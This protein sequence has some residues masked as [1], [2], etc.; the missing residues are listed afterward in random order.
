[1]QALTDAILPVFVLIGFGWIAAWR[2]LFGETA[3]DGCMKFAQSF[4]IP[5]LLFIQLSRL[6]LGQTFSLGLL[7]SFYAGAFAGFALGFGAARA[8][9]RPPVDS[10]A[11]GFCCLFSNSML[12][13]VPIT[14]RA[15]GAD[16][17]PG[18][19]SIV[20]VHSPILYSFGILAMELAKSRGQNVPGPR[21]A[22]QVVGGILRTP[23]VLGVALG[24]AVNVTGLPMP[25][26]LVQGIELLARAAIP[27]ALFG[28][29]GVLWRYRPEGDMRLIGVVVFA[30]LVVH[31]VIAYGLGHFVFGLAPNHLRPGVLLASMAPGANAYLYAN[32]YGVGRRIAASSVLVATALSILTSWA[33]IGLLP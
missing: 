13:G 15:F 18:A 28:L 17:V 8:V 3:V 5:A 20:A 27:V 26:P 4:G 29:G 7:V 1:M 9:G 23:I 22:M 11:V 30:S 25:D 19:L 32:M 21:L 10:V 31:P 12:L 2:G 16:A 33:W 6:D 14:E 24:M